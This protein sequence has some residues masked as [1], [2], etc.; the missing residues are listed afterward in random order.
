M[1]KTISAVLV[2]VMLFACVLTGCGA[3]EKDKFI[4]T[5]E[6]D[7]NLAEEM[8]KVF[9]EDEEMA[10]Y[11]KLTDFNVVMRLTFREEGTYEMSID[12]DSFMAALEGAKDELLE[13]VKRYVQDML[14]A[15]DLGVEMD[16]DAFLEMS[17][18]SLDELMDEAMNEAVTDEVL[19][20]MSSEGNFVVEKGKL[21]LSDGLDHQVDEA[22]YEVYEFVGEDLKF[23]ESVGSG[24]EFADLYPMTFKK[25]A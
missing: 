16:I 2:L 21:F 19:E 9:A 12:T 18:I 14:D 8:N 23:T 13:G 10:D 4:G 22:V 20:E 24:S 5:W 1:K 3:S 11:M 17:G 7:V 15:M 25:A 6:A